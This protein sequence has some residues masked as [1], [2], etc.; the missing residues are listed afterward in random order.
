MVAF[1]VMTGAHSFAGASFFYQLDTLPYEAQE[2]RAFGLLLAD[3]AV[4]ITAAGSS[5]SGNGDASHTGTAK[6]SVA[7]DATTSAGLGAWLRS[8]ASGRARPAAA[9]QARGAATTAACGDPVNVS[10]SGSGSGSISGG[11]GTASQLADLAARC[12]TQ[13]VGSRPS[14]VDVCQQLQRLSTALLSGD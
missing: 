9:T 14:F 12:T 8:W 5:N 4:R 2:V 3:M 11:G 13:A 7:A 10:G 6:S 1:E